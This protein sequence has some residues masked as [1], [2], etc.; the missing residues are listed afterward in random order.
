VF[1]LREEAVSHTP[2]CHVQLRLQTGTSPRNS[3]GRRAMRCARGSPVVPTVKATTPRSTPHCGY[4]DSGDSRV[5]SHR[6]SSLG[7]GA[8]GVGSSAAVPGTPCPRW[9]MR[10]PFIGIT[11]EGATAGQRLA[12]RAAVEQALLQ[13]VQASAGG[14]GVV[15]APMEQGLAMRAAVQQALLQ[16]VQANAARQHHHQQQQQR[17]DALVAAAWQAGAAGAFHGQ[18]TSTSQMLSPARLYVRPLPAPRAPYPMPASL[19]APN[20]P[21][22]SAVG[23]AVARQRAAAARVASAATVVAAPKPPNPR[24][25]SA[26]DFALRLPTRAKYKG[27]TRNA[28]RWRCKIYH[29][30]RSINIGHFDDP[31]VAAMAYDIAAR[32]LRGSRRTVNFPE[33]DLVVSAPEPLQR[34]VQQ[35]LGDT[36]AVGGRPTLSRIESRAHA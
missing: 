9:Q 17:Q 36:H 2:S 5:A 13:H 7:D 21:A 15:G 11:G 24:L 33:A 23:T 29:N 26:S 20:N 12:T 10:L 8:R 25:V 30:R 28:S 6:G 34:I 14:V 22:I 27:V 35:A 1:L 3:S 16:H 31:K 19:S 18:T 32:L 4:P